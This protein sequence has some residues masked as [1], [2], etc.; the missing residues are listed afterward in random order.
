M[1]RLQRVVELYKKSRQGRPAPP[2]NRAAGPPPPIVYTHTRSIELDDELLREQRVMATVD[3]GP[4]V[5]SYKILRT[6]VMHR[7]REHHWSV[8][9]VTSPGRGEGKTL[10]AINLAVSLAMEAAQTVLLVDADLVHPAIHRVFGL[11][12]CEGLTDYLLD[13]TPIQDLLIH[14]GIGRLVLMPGGRPIQH[15]V[16]MLTSPKM[17][18]LVEE[19]R[20]RYPSR[21]VIFDLPPLLDT[22]DVL[23]FS[24]YT[25][26]LLMVVEE[27]KTGIDAL[28]KAHLMVKG[29]TPILGTILN[30]SGQHAMSPE[31]MKHML[32]S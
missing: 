10:T 1:D 30:K 12:D 6:Q 19:F 18:S 16:E 24:P 5:D 31:T 13:D 7:L 11:D 27:G 23:A 29:V 28:E 21:V 8:L 15:S 25:D 9:A 4:F 20:D 3:P 14:P 32:L 22:A 17:V 26:A 2:R